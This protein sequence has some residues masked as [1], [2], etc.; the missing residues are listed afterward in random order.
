MA[1]MWALILSSTPFMI[2]L[3]E[4]ICIRAC[5]QNRAEPAKN[6]LFACVA[7]VFTSIAWLCISWRDLNLPGTRPLQA[8]TA[9]FLRVGWQAVPTRR[10]SVAGFNC[11]EQR[12]TLFEV[13]ATWQSWTL[14]G[15]CSRAPQ[16]RAC[17]GE[18]PAFYDGKYNR[19][20]TAKSFCTRGRIGFDKMIPLNMVNW[21]IYESI[22]LTTTKMPLLRAP[23]MPSLQL[24]RS[25]IHPKYKICTNGCFNKC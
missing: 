16:A 22:S 17:Y 12:C 21:Q 11:L 10:S 9:D 3:R 25:I 20:P 2:V 14:D 4:P 6:I 23:R 24:Q 15:S 18:S 1:Q 8:G 13:A 19:A 7:S 5:L